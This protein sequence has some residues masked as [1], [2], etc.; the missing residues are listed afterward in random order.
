MAITTPWAFY[1]CNEASGDIIDQEGSNDMSNTGASY[2]ETGHGTLGDALGFDGSDFCTVTASK[3]FSAFT[4][5]AWAKS[6]TGMDSGGGMVNMQTTGGT[7][8][9]FIRRNGTTNDTMVEIGGRGMF[10]QPGAN[11]LDTDWHHYI[12]TWSDSD[13]TIEFWI[14]GVSQGTDTGTSGT[15]SI[16]T[17]EFGRENKSISQAWGGA[18]QQVGF[19]DVRLSDTEIGELWNSG[20]G[21]AYP[22]TSDVTISPSTVALSMTNQSPSYFIDVT[23][24]AVALTL[25]VKTPTLSVPISV[26]VATIALTLNVPTPTVMQDVVGLVGSGSIGSQYIATRYPVVEG[27]I[28]GTTKQTGN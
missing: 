6:G 24:G 1:K 17:F 10:L 12:F 13:D 27:L 25:D 16:E 26:D 2:G 7:L 4:I 19:W 15:L 18:I 21:L 5:Q 23:S 8:R 11:D 9:N 14:D 22:F 3:T 28:A 20:D